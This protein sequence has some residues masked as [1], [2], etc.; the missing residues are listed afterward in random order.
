MARSF[1]AMDVKLAAAVT[2]IANVAE[3]CRQQGV[4]R[5]TFYKWRSR[6]RDQ[7]LVGL[8]DRSRR[9]K[10]SRPR[11]TADV[12]D[13]I[14]ELRKQLTDDGYDAGAGSIHGY[15][16]LEGWDPV[17]SEASIWRALGRRGFITPQPQKRPK[18]S[19]KRFVY[20][21]ANEC[22]QID[23]HEYLLADGT[24]VAIIDI[25]DDHSRVAFSRAVAPATCQSAWEVFVGAAQRW[26][27]PSMVLSDNDLVYNGQRRNVTV[28]FEANLR[29]L[30]IRP[31]TSRP[32]HPQTC[33]KV[34][35]FHQTVQK[36][37]T[38]QPSA[39]TLDELNHQLTVFA[40]HYNH[41]RPHRSLA[42]ATPADIHQQS[43][44]AGPANRP[45]TTPK[46]ITTGRVAVD[47]TVWSRPWRIAVGHK[48]Q[49]QEVTTIIDG[50]QAYIFTGDT[51]LRTLTLDPTRQ[52]QPLGCPR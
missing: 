50:D 27:L 45:V 46:R 41:H 12:E 24:K 29:R 6:F 19:L 43:S 3:F 22:W 20:E 21:R 40:D 31:I 34:E 39:E 4:S 16:V 18:S 28:R 5:S 1:T 10:T 2:E 32:Y 7:G 17:P 25:I 48:H 49:G 47:G 35:R 11:I 33:G 51:L 52:H 23:H 26:G 44:K 36:W 14:I 30:G 37:L 9:P 13:R 15:L 42:G 38:K 8:D